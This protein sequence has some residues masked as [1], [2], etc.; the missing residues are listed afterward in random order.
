MVTKV[1]Y[2][3]VEGIGRCLVEPIEKVEYL[4]NQVKADSFSKTDP[5]RQSQIGRK[6]AVGY[7][8]IAAE[9]AVGGKHVGQTVGINRS[10][11]KRS[12]RPYG[13]AFVCT[14]EIAVG[15]TGSN[16]VERP[17]R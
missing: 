15:I 12:I 7:S 6:I 1:V 11:A 9:V 10:L 5:P 13:G 17:S 4:A 8:H 3:R 16:N 14:L 2:G